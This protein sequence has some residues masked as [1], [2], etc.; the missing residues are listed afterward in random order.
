MRKTYFLTSPVSVCRETEAG[1]IQRTCIL[2]PRLTDCPHYTHSFCFSFYHLVHLNAV[3]KDSFT[4]K[5]F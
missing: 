4:Q 3:F 5:M 2:L 1:E